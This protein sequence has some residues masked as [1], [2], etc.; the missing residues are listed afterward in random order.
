MGESSD[1]E[2]YLSDISSIED[3]ACM[4]PLTKHLVP[5]LTA[6]RRNKCEAKWI[7]QGSFAGMAEVVKFK[8]NY[9]KS[10]GI[11]RDS[12]VLLHVEE[13]GYLMQREALTILNGD[14]LMTIMDIYTCI[15]IG[16]YGCTWEAFKVYLELKTLGYIVGRHNVLWSNTSNITKG[17]RNSLQKLNDGLL[18]SHF[19][20]L[21]V[22]DE[23]GIIQDGKDCAEAC[24]SSS[25]DSKES[26]G[27]CRVCM[28]EEE[29][30]Y[31]FCDPSNGSHVSARAVELMFD[32]FPPNSSFKKTNPGTPDF[33][34]CISSNLPP[35]SAYL[36]AL[37]TQSDGIPVTVAAVDSGRT[38]FFHFNEVQLPVL[39]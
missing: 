5:K 9:L 18:P 6:R 12:R 36:E 32:V 29:A 21:Q 4:L 7:S 38:S 11:V 25:S 37:N 19:E 23:K 16:D 31:Q 22:R 26:G 27:S 20:R 15:M 33:S 30:T 3:E 35:D 39:P 28:H 17:S 14:S 2:A 1:E 13:I 8:G 24:A 34:L 10:T